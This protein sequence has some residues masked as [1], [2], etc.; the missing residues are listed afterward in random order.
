LVLTLPFGILNEFQKIG[1]EFVW[2]SIPFSV[3]VS[4]V[5]TSMEKVGEATENPFEGG[6]ND[7]PIAALSRNIEIDL[8]DMLNEQDLPEPITPINNILM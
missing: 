8:R 5:F 6:A 2:L 7:I 1:N 3:I 4:W